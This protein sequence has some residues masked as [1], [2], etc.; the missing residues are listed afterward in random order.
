M[1]KKRDIMLK[2]SRWVYYNG[3]N[4]MPLLVLKKKPGL[5]GETRIRMVV[6]K[7]EI[8]EN[9]VPMSS[10]LPDIK[11][12]L[13]RVAHHRFVSIVDGRDTYE[14]MRVNPEDEEKNLIITP[15]GVMKSRVM[16]QGDKNAV[17]TWQMTM[18]HMFGPYIGKWVDPYLDDIIIYSNSIDDH[19]RHCRIVF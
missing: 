16:C 10:P 9:T 7:R 14:Q 18:C 17:A 1:E 13:D 8:N 5:N 4:G 12:I 19:I 3:T 11:A 15:D 2:S 6:D